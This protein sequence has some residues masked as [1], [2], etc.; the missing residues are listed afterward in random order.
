MSIKEFPGGILQPRC[1]PRFTPARSD[2]NDIVRLLDDLQVAFD[3]GNR[4]VLLNEFLKQGTDI[5]INPSCAK[6]YRNRGVAML[7]LGNTK[8]ACSDMKR[9]CEFGDCSGYEFLRK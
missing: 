8:M 4:V 7:K 2:V 6:A 3:D 5:E 9:G 1:G